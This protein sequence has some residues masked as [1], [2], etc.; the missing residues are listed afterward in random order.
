MGADIPEAPETMKT[1]NE[2][3]TPGSPK[4]LPPNRRTIC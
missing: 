3:G 1:T 4:T 2:T